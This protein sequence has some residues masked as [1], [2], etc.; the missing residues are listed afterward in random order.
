DQL[1]DQMKETS[2]TSSKVCK[3][4]RD[5]KSL[6]CTDTHPNGREIEDVPMTIIC[7]FQRSCKRQGCFYVHPNG[8]EIDESPSL[9]VCRQGKDCIMPDC[10]FAHPDCRAPVLMKCDRCQQLGHT[11]STCPQIKEG[12]ELVGTSKACS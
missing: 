5:C 10:I 11:K 9:G 12:G 7:R 8:R 1:V 3:Y 4:D 2:G 6:N